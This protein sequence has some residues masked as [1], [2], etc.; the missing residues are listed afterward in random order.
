MVAEL[1]QQVR[2]WQSPP[3]ADYANHLH[4][5]EFCRFP[6]PKEQTTRGSGAGERVLWPVQGEPGGSC[7]RLETSTDHPLKSPP[8]SHITGSSEVPR[9][10][11]CPILY[12]GVGGSVFSSYPDA[13]TS[14]A[15]R[16]SSVCLRLSHSG[17]EDGCLAPSSEFTYFCRAPLSRHTHVSPAV[18]Q[19]PFS[20]Q[21]T[22]GGPT[23]HWQKLCATPSHLDS[24]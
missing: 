15:S 20:G 16:F 2:P 10:D 3:A 19:G 14:E 17:L 13:D 6:S 8:R 18:L 1:A 5:E 12:P 9:L 11:G 21:W 4:T 7:L 22:T 24:F 23:G